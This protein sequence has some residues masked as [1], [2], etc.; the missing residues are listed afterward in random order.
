MYLYARENNLIGGNCIGSK[1]DSIKCLTE[2][3]RK[4]FFTRVH[5]YHY[6][7]S[8]TESFDGNHGIIA[9]LQNF[10][11]GEQVSMYKSAMAEVRAIRIFGSLDSKH[12]DLLKQGEE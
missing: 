2:G 6:Y 8:S 12:S 10:D 7:W 11:S 1:A 9:L 3:V 4:K 5:C